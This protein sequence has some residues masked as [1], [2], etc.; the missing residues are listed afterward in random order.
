MLDEPKQAIKNE[1]MTMIVLFD[2]TKAFD[3]IPHK[4]WLDELRKLDI[5]DGPIKWL[6]SYLMSKRQSVTDKNGYPTGNEQ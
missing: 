3:C 1:K 6:F 5:D 2:F 4:F